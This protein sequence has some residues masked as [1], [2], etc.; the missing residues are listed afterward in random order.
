MKK[1]LIAAA[2][3]VGFASA[4]ADTAFSL[5]G[6]NVPEQGFAYVQ[7]YWNGDNDGFD[8]WTDDSTRDP[9]LFLLNA[10]GTSV[11]ARNDDRSIFSTEALISA[12]LG[13]GTYWAAI[14]QY[15]ATDAEAI[16]GFNPSAS[17]D[18]NPAFTTE[19]YARAEDRN[20]SSKGDFSNVTGPR[21][22]APGSSTPPSN[23]V[24]EP[25][26]S[27]LIGLGLGIAGLLARRRRKG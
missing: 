19:L 10:A 24:P 17:G 8:L 12:S 3:S 9:E 7:F 6:I 1:L 13:A 22:T 16:A 5:T 26:T 21:T 27:A 15:N 20:G 14:G 23:G 25:A 11:L 2:L 4:Q 18:N